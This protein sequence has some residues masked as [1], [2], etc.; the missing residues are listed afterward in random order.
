MNQSMVSIGQVKREISE[1]VNR[2]AF[3]GERI[4]L[5]SR[6][7]PKA[8]LVS[9]EDLQAL[10]H[11]SQEKARRIAA[12]ARAQALGERIRAERPAHDV[13]SVE[14]LR[15]LREGRTDELLGMR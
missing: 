3:G 9:I 5:T 14:L 15:Q 4:I 13:D 10:D 7:K 11:T 8:A 12:L 2:V 6:G 1:L